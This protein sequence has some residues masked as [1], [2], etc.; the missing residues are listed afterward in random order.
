MQCAPNHDHVRVYIGVSIETLGC[1]YHY[2][3]FPI[4]GILFNI[5][6]GGCKKSRLKFHR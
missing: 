3:L 1:T 2:I 6:I 5:L 4:T